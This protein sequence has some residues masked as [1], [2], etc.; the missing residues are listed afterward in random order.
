MTFHPSEPSRRRRIH[1]WTGGACGASNTDAHVKQPVYLTPAGAHSVQAVQ[2]MPALPPG[3]HRPQHT[4]ATSMV[5]LSLRPAPTSSPAPY[6]NAAPGSR[7]PLQHSKQKSSISLTKWTSCT[8]LN[9]SVSNLVSHATG[10]ANATIL[11]LEDLV[12][13]SVNGGSNVRETTSRLLDQV[14][15]SMDLGSFC[16]RENELREDSP[17]YGCLQC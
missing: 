15:T 3:P 12:L 5:Q 14:I 1:K 11:E 4:A 17:G 8:D 16:G 6:P 2:G 13:N 10:K 9:Q 7:P